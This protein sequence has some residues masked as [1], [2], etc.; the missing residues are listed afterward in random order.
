MVVLINGNNH[1]C[2]IQSVIVAAKVDYNQKYFWLQPTLARSI[3]SED[4][5]LHV[6][7]I[8]IQPSDKFIYFILEINWNFN[9]WYSLSMV[10]STNGTYNQFY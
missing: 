3:F 5:Y 10:F 4:R 7:T 6:F 1:Q 2:L 9:Q 8:L